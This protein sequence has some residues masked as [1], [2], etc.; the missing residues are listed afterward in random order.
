MS[1]LECTV[2]P[3]HS[4]GMTDRLKVL[5]SAAVLMASVL[6]GCDA[7]VSERT[8]QLNQR[9]AALETVEE[10][11]GLLDQALPGELVL[12]PEG[13]WEGALSVPD[14]VTLE[15]A[16]ME[17]TTVRG[18]ISLGSGSILRSMT[19]LSPMTGLQA[20]NIGVTGGHGVLDQVRLVGW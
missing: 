11:Q 3:C 1:T 9:S 20:D 5:G 18:A 7:P 19:I 4:Q 2:E 15:G 17:Q 13:E 16:S 10:V 14:G 6:F 12:L 8:G